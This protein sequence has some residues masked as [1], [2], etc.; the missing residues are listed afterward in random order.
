[1][2][3]NFDMKKFL[4]ENKLGSYARLKTLNE[5]EKIYVYSDDG[6]TCYRVDDEGNRDEVNISYCKMYA[7]QGVREEKEEVKEDIGGD[8]GDAQAEK[9]MDF[10]AEEPDQA[11]VQ[12][13]YDKITAVMAKAAKKLSD[14]EASALHDKLKAFFNKLFESTTINEAQAQDPLMLVDRVEVI[15]KNLNNNITTNS[16]IS[17][18]DKVGLLQALKEL[19]ELIEDIGFYIEIDQD[20][21]SNE[22]PVSDYSRRRQNELS[23]NLS[24]NNVQTLSSDH[25]QLIQNIIDNYSDGGIYADP[26]M[27]RIERIINGDL[28]MEDPEDGGTFKY[29]NVNEESVRMFKSDNP[30]GDKLVL[31]FLKGIAKK[32]DYPVQQAALFVKERIKKLG[33]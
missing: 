30:E 32:F 28:S 1:M 27:D 20:E 2:A 14:D 23:E 22:E 25:I 26:A 24:S 6:Y 12:D 19:Q 8:I 21:N 18:T 10:L 9:M 5:S 17:T 16:N 11:K 15:I 7:D 13:M 33:Y 4:T 31:Q 29:E 3:D